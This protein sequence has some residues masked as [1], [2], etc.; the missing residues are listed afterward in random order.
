MLKPPQE[1][2]IIIPILWIWK[3]KLNEVKTGR[4]SSQANKG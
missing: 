1:M 2:G 3:L 4:L